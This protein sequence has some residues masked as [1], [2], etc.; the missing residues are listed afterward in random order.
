VDDPP[1]AEASALDATVL[2]GPAAPDDNPATE[3][4]TTTEP[5]QEG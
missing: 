4:A 2:I 1:A 3:P 5:P